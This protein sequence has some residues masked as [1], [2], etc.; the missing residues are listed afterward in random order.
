MELYGSVSK[1]LKH[2]PNL[3]AL[4]NKSASA[5]SP[6]FENIIGQMR[7]VLKFI[8]SQIYYFMNVQINNSTPL[9]Y[10]GL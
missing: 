8:M 2:P 9:M 3:F 5:H 10:P 6:T 4:S 7:I 1:I